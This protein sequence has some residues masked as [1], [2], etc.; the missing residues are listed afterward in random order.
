MHDVGFDG[1]LAIEG[2]MEGDHLTTNR[3][4]FGYVVGLLAELD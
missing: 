4:S 2:A 1:Y 3:R